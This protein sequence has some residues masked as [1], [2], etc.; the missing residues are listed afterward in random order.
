MTGGWNRHELEPTSPLSKAA[1]TLAQRQ[2][3]AIGLEL[4]RRHPFDAQNYLESGHETR[5]RTDDVE[6]T[7]GLRKFD[8][9]QACIADVLKNNVPGDLIA[10]GV[11]RGAVQ[12]FMGGAQGLWRHQ[13]TSMGSRFFQRAPNSGL[14]KTYPSWKDSFRLCFPAD[15]SIVNSSR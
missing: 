9:L 3:A 8:N 13:A 7:V 4:V 11:W 14:T 6:T 5:N 10:T 15:H 12:V 2:F 1:Y